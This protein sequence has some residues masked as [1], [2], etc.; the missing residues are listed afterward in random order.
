MLDI[1]EKKNFAAAAK[2]SLLLLLVVH[3]RRKSGQFY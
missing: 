3:I 2:P 1:M